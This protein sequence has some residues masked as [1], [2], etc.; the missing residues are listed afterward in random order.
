VL[1]GCRIVSSRTHL[2]PQRLLVAC[3]SFGPDLP[4]GRACA[5]IARGVLAAGAPAP[6]VCPVEPGEDLRDQLDALGFEARLHGAWAVIIGA[7]RL[8]PRDLAGSPAFEIATRARQG[9][10]PAYA[11]T[12]ENALGAF[13]ARMLDMQLILEARGARGL[14]A[15]GRRLAR[16]T[17]P[18][19]TVR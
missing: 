6:D 8:R 5:A 3:C 13:D 11:V 17:A 12:G 1:E 7:E 9:G 10:V 18:E 15:A 2:I 16:L 4:A 19:A 14:A